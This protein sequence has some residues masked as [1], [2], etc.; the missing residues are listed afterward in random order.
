MDRGISD[1]P[2]CYN[3]KQPENGLGKMNKRALMTDLYQHGV[4]FSE[5][6]SFRTVDK[7]DH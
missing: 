2:A 4:A 6:L 5:S 1:T 3:T 7:D